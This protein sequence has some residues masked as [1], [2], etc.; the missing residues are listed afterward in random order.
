MATKK[1]LEQ[2]SEMGKIQSD[3]RANYLRLCEKYGWKK[4]GKWAPRKMKEATS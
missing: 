3:V 1:K 4:P 2:R